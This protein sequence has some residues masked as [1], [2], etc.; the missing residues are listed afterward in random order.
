MTGRIVAGQV[1]EQFAH[2]ARVEAH[3]AK[4]TDDLLAR[5]DAFID[6]E[7]NRHNS[8]IVPGGARAAFKQARK[9]AENFVHGAR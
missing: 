2:V 7:G 5:G 4:H 6:A 8:L 1:V 3:V 9:V